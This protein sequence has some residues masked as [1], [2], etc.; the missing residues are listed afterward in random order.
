MLLNRRALPVPGPCANRMMVPSSMFQ[1]TCASISCNAPCAASAS[2]HPRRSPNAVGFR[3]T[4]MCSFR[5][6]NMVWSRQSLNLELGSVGRT[7]FPDAR[8]SE[9]QRGHHNNERGDEY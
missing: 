6:W 2:I 8:E 7:V 5:V 3:S 9:D 1:S 4:D